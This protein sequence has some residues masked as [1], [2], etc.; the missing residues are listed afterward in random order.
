MTTANKGPGVPKR[1]L[2]SEEKPLGDGLLQE[3][4]KVV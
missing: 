1:V 3:S 4:P 2:A